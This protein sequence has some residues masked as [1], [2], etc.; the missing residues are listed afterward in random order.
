MSSSG[1][2]GETPHDTTPGESDSPEAALK[3]ML[4][5]PGV[6]DALGWLAGDL[7][8]RLSQMKGRVF[9]YPIDPKF[10]QSN[11]L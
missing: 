11:R 10:H 4:D 3:D 5:K 8:P 1:K 2:R 6:R 7:N 9:Y